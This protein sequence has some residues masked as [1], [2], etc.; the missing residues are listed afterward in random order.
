MLW[1]ADPA[2]GEALELA[3]QLCAIDPEIAP[4]RFVEREAQAGVEIDESCDPF[5]VS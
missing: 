4:S 2:N 3:E 5:R 1:A